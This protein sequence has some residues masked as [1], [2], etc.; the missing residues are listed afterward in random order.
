MPGMNSGSQNG[1]LSLL[2]SFLWRTDPSWPHLT[3]ALD[4]VLSNQLQS[5]LIL[6]SAGEFI[7][8]PKNMAKHSRRGQ[9]FP[10]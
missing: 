2:H 8:A 9:A 1:A 5:S 6:N 4:A 10:L 7:D 3:T